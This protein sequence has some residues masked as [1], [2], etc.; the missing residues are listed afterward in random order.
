M[1]KLT[2]KINAF[3]VSKSIKDN[4]IKIS[5]LEEINIQQTCRKLLRIGID[6]YFNK[7]NQNNK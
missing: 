7:H 1:E 5:D 6:E 2:E 3:K 4:I